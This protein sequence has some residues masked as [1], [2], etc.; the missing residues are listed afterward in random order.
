MRHQAGV[1]HSWVTL[2]PLGVVEQRV[3]G[4]EAG[5]AELADRELR[6]RRVLPVLEQD[7]HCS[8]RKCFFFCE[9]CISKPKSSPNFAEF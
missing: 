9:K 7:L 3:Q 1:P 4:P 2:D 8:L 5:R 6:D